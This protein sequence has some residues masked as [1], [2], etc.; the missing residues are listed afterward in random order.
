MVRHRSL[1]ITREI[2]VGR[3]HTEHSSGPAVVRVPAL[4]RVEGFQATVV[5]NATFVTAAA[6]F[7]RRSAFP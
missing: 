6:C 3:S 5:F 4:K 1:L 2:L 7:R